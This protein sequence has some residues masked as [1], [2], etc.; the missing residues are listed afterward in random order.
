MPGHARFLLDESLDGPGEYVLERQESHHAVNVLRHRE[1]D[2]IAVFDGLGNYAEAVIVVAD[3]N[4][5]RVRVD[6]VGT[7]PHLPLMLTIATGIPKGKRWQILIE[8]CTELGVDRIIPMLSERSVAKGEGDVKKWRRWVVEAAKQSRR[9]WLPEVTEPLE[10]AEILDLAGRDGVV[11]LLADAKGESPRVF[12][13]ILRNARQAVVLI[14]P[15]GGF[16]PREI[17]ECLGRG[18]KAISLSHFTLRVETAAG[19]VCGMLR[20]ILL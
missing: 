5:V 20:D 19:M 1:G 3:R 2:A 15:E 18:A 7:E 13:D 10:F 17:G 4:A 9:S 14:G 6:E 8:K 12:R 11:L 16:S